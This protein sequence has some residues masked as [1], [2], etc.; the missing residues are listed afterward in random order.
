MNF[1][2]ADRVWIMEK[3]LKWK[4]SLWQ[5]SDND[6]KAHAWTTW[7]LCGLEI[8]S[9]CLGWRWADAPEHAGMGW[10]RLSE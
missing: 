3:Y 4:I 10:R 2:S 7:F 6:A 8:L 1:P 9:F 5:P